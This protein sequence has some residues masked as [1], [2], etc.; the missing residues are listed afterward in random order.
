MEYWESRFKSEGAMW[1]YEPSDAALFTVNLFTKL[2]FKSILIPGFGYGRNAAAFI[3]KG[4]DVTGIETSQSAIDIAK[5]NN[6]HCK[7]HKGLVTSMPFD[8]KQ[9]DGIFCYALVHLLNKWERQRFLNACYKQ[10]T[11][12]GIL[13]FTVASKDMSMFAVGKKLSKDRYEVAKGLKVFFYDDESLHKEFGKYGII[14][15]RNIEEPVKF[16]ANQEPV[17]LK[18]VICKK[19]K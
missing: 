11:P 9:F 16:I 3:S 2:Q 15:C 5:E 13:V 12:E 4:F 19:Q 7:I 8:N 10:L 18:M 6:L 14:E 1:K 17:K